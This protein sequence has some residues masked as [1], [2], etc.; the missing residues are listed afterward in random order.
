MKSTATVLDDTRTDGDP[1]SSRRRGRKLWLAGAA[2]ALAAY[3]LTV[4]ALHY[5]GDSS[6]RVP[7][8]P[9]QQGTGVLDSVA[10]LRNGPDGSGDP[11]LAATSVP[12]G[13]P[14]AVEVDSAAAIARL[15]DLRD[16]REVARAGGANDGAAEETP[17]VAAQ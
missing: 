4:G 15:H 13:D 6:A 9:V 14:T 17:F 3:A 7:A 2:C 16:E 12:A 8:R 5:G 11:S 1:I 10:G